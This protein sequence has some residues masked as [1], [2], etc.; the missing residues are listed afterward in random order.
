VGADPRDAVV[1][2]SLAGN[3]IGQLSLHRFAP[4]DKGRKFSPDVEAAI[5]VA[6][7]QVDVRKAAS[8]S[9]ESALRHTAREL[10]QQIGLGLTRRPIEAGFFTAARA[11]TFGAAC[12]MR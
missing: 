10:A 2:L 7:Y 4:Y 8:E 6:A 9:V 5:A 11:P 1:G 12:P 3:A